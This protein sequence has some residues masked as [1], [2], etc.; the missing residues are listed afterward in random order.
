[1]AVNW[2]RNVYAYCQ[3]AFSV[4]ITVHPIVSQAEGVASYAARGIFHTREV[5]VMAE[6]G[7]V[8]VDQETILDIRTAE[9]AVPPVQKDRI[10][11]PVDSNDEPQGDFEVVST[12]VNG[13]GEMTLVLRKIKEARPL[14]TSSS[15]SPAGF[16]NE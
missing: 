15:W 2:S 13:G 10:T 4:P 11:I 1:M 7:S 9:F 12:S 14:H 16:H 8:F 6:E 5:E 3:N